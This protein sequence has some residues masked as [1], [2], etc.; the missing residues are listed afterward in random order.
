M[1]TARNG[2]L[3]HGEQV[4]MLG[5]DQ[6]VLQLR[7]DHFDAGGIVRMG[8]DLHC[9][10]PGV[11]SCAQES[12]LQSAGINPSL[13]ERRERKWKGERAAWIPLPNSSRN[14]RMEKGLRDR[15]Q[16]ITTAISRARIELFT[17]RAS[18]IA[19]GDRCGAKRERERK[20][21][22]MRERKR[23]RERGEREYLS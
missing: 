6:R 19:P 20:R 10:R 16:K 1:M 15:F 4:P 5:V 2:D 12:N 7:L 9:K 11:T 8:D 23:E 13:Q 18:E 17:A 3:L 21:E 22:R 14:E